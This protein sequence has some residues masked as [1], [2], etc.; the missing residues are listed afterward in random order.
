MMAAVNN[1]IISED[2]LPLEIRHY[3]NKAGLYQLYDDDGESFD[4]EKGIYSITKLQ[5]SEKGGKL[6]GKVS[7]P[8]GS[9]STPY[10][11]AQWIFMT[12]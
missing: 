1:I 12:Q 6:N 4:F 9:W 7:D 8:E 3:G 11:E 5:V 10:G 2:P